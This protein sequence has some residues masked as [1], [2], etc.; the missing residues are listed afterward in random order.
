MNEQTRQMM[1]EAAIRAENWLDLTLSAA[2]RSPL[3]LAIFAAWTVA[4][5]LLGWWLSSWGSAALA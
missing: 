3:T 2:V 1:R 4:M 5:V